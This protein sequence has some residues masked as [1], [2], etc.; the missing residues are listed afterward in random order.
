MPVFHL[1]PQVQQVDISGFVLIDYPLLVYNQRCP[2][3]KPLTLKRY[4]FK[5]AQD[6]VDIF[7]RAK[8]SLRSPSRTFQ[9]VRIPFP[10]TGNTRFALLQGFPLELR[11]HK[12]YID[13]LSEWT[14][15]LSRGVCDFSRILAFTAPMA[16][17][18]QRV[19]KN[20]TNRSRGMLR[21]P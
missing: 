1:C 10:V 15:H 2:A 12:C 9:H 21:T 19:F 6:V 5:H 8:A 20:V 14:A 17:S 4:I 13:A 11:H 16:L 3:V 18:G 7:E